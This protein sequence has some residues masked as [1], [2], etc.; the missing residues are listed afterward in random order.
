MP[1]DV[2]MVAMVPS[3]LLH[4]PPPPSVN[5]VVDPTHTDAVPVM[6]DG[7][8]FTLIV[9]VAELEQLPFDAVMV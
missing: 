7:N 6:A 9:A 5:V 2:P 4:E 1:E 8:A 3:L